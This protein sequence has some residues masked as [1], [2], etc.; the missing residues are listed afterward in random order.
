MKELTLAKIKEI[1]YFTIKY[2]I[3]NDNKNV[4]NIGPDVLDN[5]TKPVIELV[6]NNEYESKLSYARKAGNNGD[7]ILIPFNS[8]LNLID[9]DVINPKN[10]TPSITGI[11]NELINKLGNRVYNEI[12]FY[13]DV[14]LPEVDSYRAKV[15]NK[16]NS[17][18]S[19]EDSF[20]IR[21]LEDLTLTKLL[22]DKGILDTNKYNFANDFVVNDIFNSKVLRDHLDTSP[23]EDI[24]ILVKDIL[25]NSEYSYAVNKFNELTEDNKTFSYIRNYVTKTQ[26]GDYITLL[27]L[28]VATY[29]YINTIDDKV[30]K[31]NITHIL[32]KIIF[33]LKSAISVYNIRV[34]RGK[35]II[36]SYRDKNGIYYIYLSKE[37]FSKVKEENPEITM[38]TVKGAAVYFANNPDEAI[39]TFDLNK[40][41]SIFNDQ[42]DRYITYKTLKDKK[43]SEKKLKD[44]YVYT[45]DELSNHFLDTL[46]LNKVKLKKQLSDY[47]STIEDGKILDIDNTS[48]EIFGNVFIPTTNFKTF[49]SSMNE[50][51]L[52]SNEDN[53][54]ELALYATISLLGKYLANQYTIE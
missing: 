4:Y 34:K 52:I 11:S 42:F 29:N 49:V 30:L 39:D 9:N 19:I 48:L 5:L 28:T 50:M 27:L 12:L 22:D 43:E 6:T 10:Y 17:I 37:N 51:K 32:T 20:I 26:V 53:P 38:K 33:N 18:N 1:S 8:I 2:I 24:N 23:Y 44:I 3:E 36:E 16:I 15:T 47:L 14:V 35:S 54:Q 41:L 31:L 13:K 46:D 25:K 7:K 21:Y 45:V 40:N